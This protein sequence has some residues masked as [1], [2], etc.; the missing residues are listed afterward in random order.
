MYSITK[1]V[2]SSKTGFTLIELLIVIAII[3]ILAAIAIPNFLLAQVRAKVSH[4]YS[5]MQTIATALEAYAIDHNA[6]PYVGY[7]IDYQQKLVPL[8]TPVAYLSSLP[9]YPWKAH[10]PF[11]ASEAHQYYYYNDRKSFEDILGT[12]GYRWYIFDAT[13]KS[14]WYLSCVGPDGDYDQEWTTE[15]GC[16]YHLYDPTNGTISNGD[17]IRLGP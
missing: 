17:L 1:L 12:W 13:E 3:A 15:P 10:L 11:G 8:T 4:S 16:N 5:S 7:T 14:R 9:K 6:Y 2:R